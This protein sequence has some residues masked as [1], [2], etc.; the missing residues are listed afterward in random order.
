MR[1]FQN[2]KNKEKEVIEETKAVEKAVEIAKS[3]ESTTPTEEKKITTT[4]NTKKMPKSVCRV[5]VATPSYFVIN[6]D[7]ETITVKKKN[8]YHKGEEIY[9]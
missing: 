6:K 4:K 2:K 5:I 8:T 9:Y 3:V 7:G 1:V